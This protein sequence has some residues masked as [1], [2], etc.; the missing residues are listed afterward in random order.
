MTESTSGTTSTNGTTGFD[1]ETYI[2]NYAGFT[3]LKRMGFIAGQSTHLKADVLRSAIDEVKKTTNTVLY[4]ELI[5]MAGDLPGC[6]R[7]DAWVESEDKKATQ[8]LEKLENDLS[9]HKTSLVKDSI[10]M[11]HNDLGDFH[12]AR[13][14]F[15]TALKCYVRTRDYCTTSKH[16]ITMCLNVI[17]VSIHMGNFTHVANYIAKAESTDA[18]GSDPILTA[19]LKV[20]GGLAQLESKKYKLAARKFL[21]TNPELGSS[22]NEVLSPQ[23]VAVYGG[24]CALASFDRAEL[25]AKVVDNTNFR[26]FLEL[27][28]EVREL[29]HD[30]YNSRYASCLKILDKLKADLLL[31]LHLHDHVETL[32]ADIRSKAL[33]QYF[34]PFVTVDMK[35]MAEAFNTPV[36]DLE[37]ELAK[38]IMA[39]QIPARIDSH[40][41]VLHARHAD[42]RTATFQ[43]ALAMGDEYVRDSMALLL[44][45]NLMR[46]D[47]VVKPNHSG[48]AGKLGPSKSSRQERHAMPPQDRQPIAF[49]AGI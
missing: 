30:F 4:I 16:I 6:V 20:A 37:R 11:G 26:I 42:Q 47:F 38:L 2:S 13:G 43:K 35:L 34:S 14:D 24:L 27:V 18:S 21:E 7:D 22:F 31:D 3:R 45:I 44:R 10:R 17:R 49:E 46:H 8:R 15:A 23:D 19:Q 36:M 5:A 9:Q 48:D 1:V 33:I 29:T 40:N 32:Y 39:G 12:S 25:K 28:P 41:K